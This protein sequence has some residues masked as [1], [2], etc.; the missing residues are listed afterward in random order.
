M[1][2]VCGMSRQSGVA[3]NVYYVAINLPLFLEKT[4]RSTFLLS[5]FRFTAT[6][7][8]F[9]GFSWYIYPMLKTLSGYLILISFLFCPDYAFSLIILNITWSLE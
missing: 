5:K 8:I 6:L 9:R 3:E 4:S 2:K 7:T 1:G